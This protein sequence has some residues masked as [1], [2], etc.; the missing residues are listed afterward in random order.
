L[1]AI[2]KFCNKMDKPAEMTK[3]IMNSVLC[4]LMSYFI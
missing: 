1:F 4:F 3:R 2:A